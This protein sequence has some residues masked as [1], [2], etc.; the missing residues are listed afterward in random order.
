MTVDVDRANITYSPADNSVGP[1]FTWS[2]SI[3]R[4]IRGRKRK[5]W[6]ASQPTKSTP[7]AMMPMTS[8]SI[9][10][11]LNAS[12]GAA[13]AKPE[14]FKF[15]VATRLVLKSCLRELEQ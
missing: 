1:N 13:F 10:P 3:S 8:A 6:T 2:N 12:A 11:S 5:N 15:G 14:L 7:T 9:V 4:N